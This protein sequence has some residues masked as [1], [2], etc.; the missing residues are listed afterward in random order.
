MY[1]PE[2]FGEDRL[3]VMHALIRA[4]P[5]GVLVTAGDGGLTATHVPFLLDAEASERGTLRA[6]LA[7]PNDQLAALSA[8][9]EA[10][11]IFQGPQAYVTPAWYASKAEHGKVVP[12]WN[13]VTVHA[14]GQP[15]VIE[16]AQR[17]R[18]QLERLTAAQEAA[19]PHPWA[20][21]DAPDAYVAAMMR[22]IVG[23]EI[24][25]AR[26]EGKWKASQ[27]RDAA[28]RQGVA[29]GLNAEGETAMA[30]CV[31]ERGSAD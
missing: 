28:D 14:W 6:H 13:Y 8:G 4:H 11:V 17:L 1:R 19:R 21:A 25:I 27:N 9:G 24:P 29:A 10:L 22:G 15:R 20:V 2:P 30:A 7:R 23:L 3:E 12:T 31:A 26:I 5:L 16:D 18:D